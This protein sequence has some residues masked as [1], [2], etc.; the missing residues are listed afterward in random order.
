MVPMDSAVS[1][2]EEE[3]EGVAEAL[4]CS[5]RTVAALQLAALLI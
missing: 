5:P 2:V 4:S 3:A 1:A